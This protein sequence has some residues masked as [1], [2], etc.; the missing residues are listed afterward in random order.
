MSYAVF[1][2]YIGGRVG[3]EVESPHWDEYNLILRSQRGRLKGSTVRAGTV[4]AFLIDPAWA[5]LLLA[6]P[7]TASGTWVELYLMETCFSLIIKHLSKRAIMESLVL[8]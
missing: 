1:Y 4:G 7:P 5:L 2:V 3:G 6:F 8:A